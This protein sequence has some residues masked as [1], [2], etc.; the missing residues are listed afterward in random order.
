MMSA[1]IP[2]PIVTI[3]SCLPGK[4]RLQYWHVCY[5]T[6]NHIVFYACPIAGNFMSYWYCNTG[7]KPMGMEVMG[8]MVDL[9]FLVCKMVM[10]SNN[11]LNIYLHISGLFSILFR[12]AMLLAVIV[13]T[14]TGFM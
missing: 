12:E 10:L 8:P 14:Y 13:E 3:L 11:F 1:L 9:P 4:M 2:L 5:N 6:T 7:K